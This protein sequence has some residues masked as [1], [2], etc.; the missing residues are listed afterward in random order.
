MRDDENILGILTH[1]FDNL[2][3]T[4]VRALDAVDK[5]PGSHDSKH[6]AFVL[7]T[8][9][10]ASLSAW[11][12]QDPEKVK[13]FADAMR[14]MTE[15]L[16][17]AP[18]SLDNSPLWKEIDKPGATFVDVG[19]GHGHVSF[20]VART[21]DNLRLVVQDLPEVVMVAEASVPVEYKDRL[22]FQTHDFYQEQA[23]KGA[24][25]YFLRKILHGLPDYTSLEVLRNLIPAL[26]AGSK[27]VVCEYILPEMAKP[28][29]DE[30]DAR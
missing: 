25:V 14:V 4:A 1:A 29:H 22:S 21:T 30:L 6:T 2:W 28:S 18:D 15:M 20:Q 19:G 7:R 23:I 16:A 10:T 12:A 9:W 5:W 24:E 13:N 27:V 11:F 26:K 3:P 17:S 8:G